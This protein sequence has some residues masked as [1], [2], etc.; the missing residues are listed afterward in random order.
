MDAQTKAPTV[1]AVRGEAAKQNKP[2]KC[3]PQ[4]C[5][6]FE[7]CGATICPLDPNWRLRHHQRG[8]RVCAFLREQ[9]KPGGEAVFEGSLP[10]YIAQA[11]AEAA[12]GIYARWDTLKSAVDRAGTTG[13]KIASGRRLT[14][15]VRR[16]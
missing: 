11:I 14:A 4:A 15:G 6:R 13:S 10:R 16:G 2:A 12:P 3:T 9:A 8:D 5:P 7:R 1:G